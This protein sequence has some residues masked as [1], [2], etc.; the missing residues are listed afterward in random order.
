[1]QKKPLNKINIVSIVVIVR[2]KWG[3]SRVAVA[4]QSAGNENELKYVSR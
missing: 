1:M 2:Y 4:D 3:F